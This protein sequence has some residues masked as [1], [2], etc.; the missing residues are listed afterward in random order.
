MNKQQTGFILAL[1][2]IASL[3]NSLFRLTS[4]SAEVGGPCN[5]LIALAIHCLFLAAFFSLNVVATVF[6]LKHKGEKTRSEVAIV[7]S[8]V[9][10]ALC[11][12]SAKP[13]LSD[14][15]TSGL[16]FFLPLYI[17]TIITFI[18]SLIKQKL[19]TREQLDASKR[20]TR[21]GGKR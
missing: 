19:D 12:I 20:P 13:F 10:L 8:G 21:L 16:K 1:I 2:I 5:T 18:F 3:I 17:A 4:Y 15:F 6:I 14:N 7:T 11:I 9:A